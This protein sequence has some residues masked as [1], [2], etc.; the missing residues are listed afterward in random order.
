LYI[1]V[2]K[3]A[4]PLFFSCT[5]LRNNT[6]SIFYIR[7]KKFFFF[8]EIQNNKVQIFKDSC[9]LQVTSDFYQIEK[10]IKYNQFLINM[11][12]RG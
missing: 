3:L 7:S 9:S 12:L 1:N 5:I 6:N 10:N 11:L 8:A 2:Q 4:T